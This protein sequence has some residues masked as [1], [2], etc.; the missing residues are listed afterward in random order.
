MSSSHPVG[1]SLHD[2]AGLP[3]D[4]FLP[5]N[6][7]LSGQAI[8]YLHDLEKRRPQDLPELKQPLEKTGLPIIA[9]RGGESWWLGRALKSFQSEL[10]AEAYLLGPVLEA[11]QKHFA[12]SPPT[13]GLLG[14]EMGGQGVLQLAYRYPNRFPVAAAI[15]PAIDFHQGMQRGH[16]WSD[17]ERFASL[18]EMFEDVEEARQETALLHIHPLNWPRH[19]WFASDPRDLRWHDGAVRLTSK[20][21]ALGIPHTAILDR[22]A[23]SGLLKAFA[24]EAL[25]FIC[26]ALDAESRRLT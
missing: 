10:T 22:P 21:T 1:W 2:L 13:I 26:Q 7:T 3:C 25:A 17:G 23:E 4:L 12:V 6:G 11:F 14:T 8:L 5:A 9:P 16:E 15:G 19:Q 18:W 24:S 20:L